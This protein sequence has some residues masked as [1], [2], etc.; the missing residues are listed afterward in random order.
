MTLL[1][2]RQMHG[3]SAVEPVIGHHRAEHRMS[4]NYLAHRGGGAASAIL[5]TAGCNF[6]L[7]LRRL[8]FL[9]HQIMNALVAEPC[10]N[11]A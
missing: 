3:R 1:I 7:L 5:V 4:R 9:L 6:S 8:K 11:L 10:S 2:T